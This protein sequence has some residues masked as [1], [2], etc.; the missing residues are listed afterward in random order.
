MLFQHLNFAYFEWNKCI[1]KNKTKHLFIVDSQPVSYVTGSATLVEKHVVLC[2]IMLNNN[3]RWSTTLFFN[4]VLC[5]P[6]SGS[7][8]SALFV[9]NQRLNSS[10]MWQKLKRCFYHQSYILPACAQP[11]I[12]FC[13]IGRWL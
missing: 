8:N 3:N 2:D 9:L 13:F 12:L 10:S 11:E 6:Y 7:R 5:N 4:I 1:W